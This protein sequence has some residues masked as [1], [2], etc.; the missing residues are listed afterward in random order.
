M[1]HFELKEDECR[2]ILMGDEQYTVQQ[3]RPKTIDT[4]S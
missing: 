4:G 2:Y 3:R 1:F